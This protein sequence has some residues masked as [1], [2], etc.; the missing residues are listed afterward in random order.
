MAR[1]FHSVQVIEVTVEFVEPMDRRQIFIAVSQ[2]VLAELAGGVAHGLECRR[3]CHSLRGN[4]D[5]GSRL[6]DGGHAGANGKLTGDKVGTAGGATRFRIVVGEYHAFS[7]H[8]V[9]VWCTPGHQPATVSA[10]V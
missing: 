1:I 3:N 10:N 2:V 5:W 9:Q 6:P 8:L 7:G 4:A